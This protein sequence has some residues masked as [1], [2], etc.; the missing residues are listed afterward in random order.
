MLVQLVRPLVR[1]QVHMLSQST[2]ASSKLV[3][4]VSQWLGYLGIQAEVTQLK[5]AGDRIQVSLY[6]GKP[7]QCTETEWRQILN[8][9]TATDDP[10][11]E[12][13]L[14]AYSAMT[15]AQQ[16]KAHRL[17]AS[18]IQAGSD[19][20]LADWQTL[21]PQL[22]A[23]GLEETLL[24]GIQAALKAP[25][26]ME[27]LVEQVDPEVAA[28]VLSKAIHIALLDRQISPSEDTALKA[29]LNALDRNVAV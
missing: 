6:V 5:T 16:S 29:L 7:D 15:S 10:E 24:L 9:L 21:S 11:A 4:M 28:F 19:N 23:F 14:L 27:L 8:N 17:L 25:M 12:A 13:P 1:T 2:T 18:V 26:P 22:A 20:P 3:G